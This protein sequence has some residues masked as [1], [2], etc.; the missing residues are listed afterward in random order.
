MDWKTYYQKRLITPEEAVSHVKSGDRV[1]FGCAAGYSDVL[2]DALV[3]DKDRLTNVEVTHMLMLGHGEY[4]K[5]DMSEHLRM[6]SIF[7][8]GPGRTAVA[9][10]YADYTP[11]FFYRIPYLFNEII[12]TDVALP[13]DVAMLQVSPPDKHGYCS[14]GVAVDYDMAAARAAKM[15]ILHINKNMPRCH[16]D[17]HIHVT[18]ADFF[19]EADTPIPELQPPAIGDVERAIGNYCASLI[20]DGATLQLGI[21]ALPDAVLLFLKNKNDLGIHTEM[22]SDG[23]I[24]LIENGVINGKRKTLHREKAVSSFLMGTRRLYDFVDD[25]PG[26]LMAPVNYV[27]DPNVI[28][29]NDNMV[30]INSCVQVDFTGQVCSESIGLNQISGVGGQV[31]FVRGAYMSK[32]GKSIIAINSSASKGK[33]SKITPFLDK[34]AAVT[35]SRNEVEYIVTE[36]GIALLKGKTLRDRARALITIAHPNFRDEFSEEF[37]RRFKEPFKPLVEF[38]APAME[39]QEE[40]AE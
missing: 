40:A 37:E 25:N 36:N 13:T 4:C 2:G 26:V 6:N 16:G 32:G 31:D 39:E 11:C 35:T 8:G 18:D 27:N 34:G 24:D 7:V 17:C 15:L 21:G 28:A 12:H 1:A 22:F 19:V 10:G 3:A 30:S 29:Q 23:V 9:E 14:F 20:P 5:Q 33:I 38:E